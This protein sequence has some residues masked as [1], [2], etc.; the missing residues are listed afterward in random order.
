MKCKN[1]KQEIGQ[2][3]KYEVINCKCGARLMLVEIRKVKQLVEVG[4][5]L[6]KK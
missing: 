5:E 3:K 4:K 1:C 2:P 6:I